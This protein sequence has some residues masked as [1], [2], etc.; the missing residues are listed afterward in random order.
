M[1]PAGRIVL[2]RHPKP[3][4]PPGLCYGQ[5]DVALSDGWEAIL[6]PKVAELSG[7]DRIITSP[8]AR[9][10]EPAE[11][12]ARRLGVPVTEE[13]RLMELN[14]GEW[15]GRF[16]TDFD[17]PESRAW[18]EDFVH[19]APP[20]GEFLT[21]LADR[22]RAA[23]TESTEGHRLL[24]THG[25]PIRVLRA[26]AEGRSLYDAFTVDVPYA[27]LIPLPTAVID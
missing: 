2:M 22:V 19:R 4:V 1:N 3:A 24:V 9:C 17:G 7:I 15:E 8:L 6:A 14:F 12:L 26:L 27:E 21:A 16:W 5:S 13:P 18:A 11:W 23:V 10:R 20:G 25:G